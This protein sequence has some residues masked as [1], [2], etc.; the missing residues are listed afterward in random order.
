MIKNIVFDMGGVLIDFNP[1]MTVR[2]HFSKEYQD[3]VLKNV[4]GNKAWSDMDKGILDAKEALPSILSALPEEIRDAVAP[5]VMDFYPWM[6][7]FEEGEKL[8]KQVKDRGFNCY[9]LSNATPKF[10]D[11]V[12]KIPVMALLDGIF[13]SADY[14]MLKPD[15]EIYL[16]F[17]EVFSLKA[18]ECFFIDDMKANILG[19]KKAGIDGFVFEEKDFD[20]LRNIIFNLNA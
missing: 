6:P 3:I 20:N 10:Y 12:H 13:I 14:K 1:K 7:P 4:F 15:T 9:L 17:L 18:S 2:Q 5:M 19:A 8:V 11:Y 16:K